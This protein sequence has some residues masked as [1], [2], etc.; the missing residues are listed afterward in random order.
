MP[1]KSGVSHPL[2]TYSAEIFPISLSVQA[3]WESIQ[4]QIYHAP[5][6]V[7]SALVPAIPDLS[8]VMVTH[9]GVFLEIRNT[10]GSGP[11]KA[12][13]T[14]VGDWF[15]IPGGMPYEFRWRDKDLSSGPLQILRLHLSTALVQR[16]SEQLADRDP[17]HVEFVERSGFRDPLLTQIGLALQQDLQSP[18]SQGKLYAETAAQMLA[19]HLFRYYLTIENSIEEP[20][21][22]LT[23]QQ[24]KRVIEYILAH[25]D[26]NL[27]LEV[28]SQQLGFSVFHFAR[29]FRQ[30]TGESPH[31]FVLLKRI[32][33]AQH[34]L[35]TTDRPLAQVALEMG[36]PNQSH[37]TQV[38][39][40]HIGLTPLQYRQDHQIKAHF[41]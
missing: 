13:Y 36:F 5:A 1:E 40:K 18:V 4:G 23:R 30:A 21:Q 31:R 33:A 35:E 3:G 37:F 16:V 2:S 9:G 7:E 28:L 19:V 17:A 26:Q 41:E 32:E 39:K 38:F 14:S 8:L 6:Q 24:V 22:R 29:L 34:L 25:L 11:W 10:H 15:L 27:S 12:L 20:L